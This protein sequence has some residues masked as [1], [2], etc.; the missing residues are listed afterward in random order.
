[1]GL[2]CTDDDSPC[3][4]S[5]GAAHIGEKKVKGIIHWVNAADA[6]PA[7]IR[8]YDRLFRAANPLADKN[9]DFRA[10]LNPDSLTLRADARVEAS[11][12]DADAD[13]R[14]QFE[15]LGYFFADSDADTN[16][17]A[18][19]LVFNRIVTLRDGWAAIE[20]NQNRA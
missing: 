8:L 9:A 13:T 4:A 19:K 3:V 2:P 5:P 6:A 20:R 10:S 18:D 15:R 17:G 16:S 7:E 12:R 11:L 14:W 1:F